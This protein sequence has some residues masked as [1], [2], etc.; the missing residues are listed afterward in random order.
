MATAIAL[1]APVLPFGPPQEEL[2]PVA[3]VTAEH[4][5]IEID[6]ENGR[7]FRSHSG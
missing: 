6:R 2:A 1:S 3:V 4:S 5:I 7:P